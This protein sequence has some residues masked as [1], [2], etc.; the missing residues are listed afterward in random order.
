MK[1]TTGLMPLLWDLSQ[2]AASSSAWGGVG[3]GVEGGG[4]GGK[5]KGGKK[6]SFYGS[7]HP[8][9]R[10]GLG[11]EGKEKEKRGGTREGR[12]GRA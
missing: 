4:W 1:P 3:S 9:G 11:W 5:G 2:S 8:L 7:V 12:S 6:V 10:F